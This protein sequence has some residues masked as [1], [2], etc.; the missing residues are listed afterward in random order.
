MAAFGAFL[1][2][3]GAA[4]ERLGTG[5][6][7]EYAVVETRMSQDPILLSFDTIYHTANCY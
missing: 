7:G 2:Q 4:L 1:R 3:A 6:Q 5:L